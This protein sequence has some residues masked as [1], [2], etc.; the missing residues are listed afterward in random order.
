MRKSKP[1]IKEIY[2]V[3]NIPNTG[4][5]VDIRNSKLY[6]A[7]YHDLT[8]KEFFL[9]TISIYTMN[10]VERINNRL[11]KLLTDL[12][13]ISEDE[14]VYHYVGDVGVDYTAQ[15]VDFYRSIIW[16]RTKIGRLLWRR[17]KEHMP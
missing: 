9:P 15:L 2:Y 10:D 1:L 3:T 13:S 17:K 8:E 5:R 11:V 14:Y 12:T 6:P 4:L 7:C 16:I